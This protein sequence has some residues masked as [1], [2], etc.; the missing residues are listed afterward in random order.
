MF[1]PELQEDFIA[2]PPA[3]RL[4]SDREQSIVNVQTKKI[5]LECIHCGHTVSYTRP[6]AACPKCGENILEARYDLDA[7]R[8]AGWIDEVVRREPGL[9]R[10]HE[11]LPL[12]DTTNIVSLGEGWTPL[13]HAR[14]LGMMLGLKH[15]YIKD[16]RQGPTASFKDRQASVAISVMREQGISEAV[17]A[18]TGNV[19]IA[20][21]AYAARAGIKMW[22]FLTSMVPGEKMREAAI[23]GGEI[24]KVTGTYDQAKIV[25]SSFADSRGLFLDRGI[26]SV[27]AIE[28][29]KTMA[30]EMVEQLGWQSPDWFI[31]AVSGGMGPIGVA[32]GFEEMRAMGIVDRVPALGVIQSAGCAPMVNAF[33]N[34]QR[35]ATPV[36]NPQTIIATLSTGNPGRAYELLYDLIG[37][38]GG[39]M[40]TATDEEAFNATKLLA[41]T[42]GLSVEPATAVAFAGLIKLARRGI[43][44]PHEVVVINCS[45]HTLAVEK[46]ILGD[47]FER[48]VDVS[49]KADKV[50]VPEEGLLSALE[51]MEDAI[52]RIVVIEDNPAAGRLISRI[53]QAQGKYE[54][55]L[56]DGGAAGIV[57]VERIKP[58]L[59]ITD[60]MMPDFDGF[61]IIDALKSDDN[62]RNIPIIVLTAKE[63]TVQERERLSGQIERLL[64]KGS[65]MDED[66]LQSIVEALK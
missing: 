1:Y 34:G 30:F 9:W 12:Y 24:I 65:F 14:N 38:N 32:K 6:L 20:Y 45:G 25:A 39:T 8:Q 19:A 7:L 37:Q 55:H 54:V 50:S 47:R 43:I 28:S 53:L 64:Q 33:K 16:E 18:S 13:L 62:T 60:L 51:Q 31:Q 36:E 58:D 15:L 66:L 11:L 3:P 52:R 49:A 10:Y 29:M 41:R 40:E 35:V 46:Q 21:S 17:V 59:V 48:Q 5:E 4:T 2:G 26:K 63:L 56:A 23:Y 22:S 61:K 44:K 57:L 42:E 27:A